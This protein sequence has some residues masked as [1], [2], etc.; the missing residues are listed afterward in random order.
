M[1]AIC[2]YIDTNWEKSPEN[3]YLELEKE[4]KEEFL[5]KLQRF[6]YLA[7]TIPN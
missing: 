2:I 3:Q 1:N 5:E 7:K 4:R 6:H